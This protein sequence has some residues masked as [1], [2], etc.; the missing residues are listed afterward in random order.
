[1]KRGQFLLLPG[2]VLVRQGQTERSFY[3]LYQGWAMRCQTLEDGTQQ[4]LD[5]LLPGDTV[6]LGAIFSPYVPYSVRALT[7]AV[8]CVLTADY[9]PALFSSQPSLALSIL[10]ERLQEQDRL[11]RRLTSLGRMSAPQ[12]IGHL[13]MELRQRLRERG[14]F[15]GATCDCP[16]SRGE[17]A[18][19]VGLSRP[20][21]MRALREL[22][23]RGLADLHRRQLTVQ[24]EQDLARYCE[25]DWQHP[26]KIRTLL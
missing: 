16:I 20:H 26:D 14:M 23:T 10:Q 9:F 18:N 12:R 3:T 2:E 7:R 11:E 22:R 17:L 5:F 13:L 25:F 15:Q 19:A 4:I 6:G 24:D 21:V 1:M 8:V